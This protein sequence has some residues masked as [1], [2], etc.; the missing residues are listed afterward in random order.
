MEGTRGGS[1]LVVRQ[2]A[3]VRF[4]ARYFHLPTVRLAWCVC[5]ESKRYFFVLHYGTYEASVMCDDETDATARGDGRRDARAHGR[6]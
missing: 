3:R 4:V 1:R 5:Y 6:R 2:H